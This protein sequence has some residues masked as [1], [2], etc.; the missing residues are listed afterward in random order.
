M[1]VSSIQYL[2]L[3]KDK[4]WKKTVDPGSIFGPL[5]DGS[6]GSSTI[7]RKTIYLIRHGES[8][9]NDTFNKGT[10]RS[11]LVFV[12]GWVPGLIKA[13]L[14]ELYLLLSGKF[15]S[16]FYDSPLSYLG[17]SQVEKLAEFIEKAPASGPEQAMMKVIRAD[18]GAPNSL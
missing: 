6:K 5:L 13:C 15:D 4:K 12:L 17:L 3:C 7:E 14:Y 18:P 11:T 9:W 10:H 2:L 1:T 8:T 16:W